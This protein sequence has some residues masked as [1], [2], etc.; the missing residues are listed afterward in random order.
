MV[1]ISAITILY[2]LNLEQAAIQW[3]WIDGFFGMAGESKYDAYIYAN[4]GPVWSYLITNIN[5]IAL[6][7][8]AD[9]LLV[10]VFFI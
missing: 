9:S 3:F 8:I 10:R 6:S 4:A 7:F 2:L 5:A 1:V